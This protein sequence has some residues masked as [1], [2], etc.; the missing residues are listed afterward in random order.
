MVPSQQDDVPVQIAPREYPEGQRLVPE[1][2]LPEKPKGGA[3]KKVGADKRAP[4]RQRCN[5]FNGAGGKAES[6][7]QTSGQEIV[8]N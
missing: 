4:G 5:Q 2:A 1:F 8:D 6:A 7:R 3:P